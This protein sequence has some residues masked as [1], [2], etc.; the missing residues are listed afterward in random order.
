MT[1]HSA[2][3]RR[4]GT[5]RTRGRG[6]RRARTG[7]NERRRGQRRGHRSWTARDERRRHP[8][9]D[10]DGRRCRGGRSQ[11]RR[12]SRNGR[13]ALHRR[14]RVDS[15]PGKRSQRRRRRFRGSRGQG[16]RRRKPSMPPRVA[17]AGTMRPNR[18]RGKA[19]RRAADA[20]ADGKEKPASGGGRTGDANSPMRKSASKNGHPHFPVILTGNTVVRIWKILE[21]PVKMTGNTD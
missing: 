10:D 16:S 5:R 15:R 4:R 21:N 12:M 7:G 20:V 8:W 11:G 13:R 14:R 18:G 2:A 3:G 1:H 17:A 9:R 6:C 19:P